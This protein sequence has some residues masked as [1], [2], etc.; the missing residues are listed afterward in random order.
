MASKLRTLRLS[1]GK[2][3][4]FRFPDEE[5]KAIE[6]AA[7]S[8][9]YTWTD[10]ARMLIDANPDAPNRAALLRRA[11]LE[12]AFGHA[13]LAER[14]EL[15]QQGR[16]LDHPMLARRF[17]PMSDGALEAELELMG[18]PSYRADCQSFELIAGFHKEWIDGKEKQIPVVIIRN[19]LEGGLH[20][21]LS[22]DDVDPH[23]APDLGLDDLAFDEHDIFDDLGKAT[24]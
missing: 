17:W 7:E 16:E 9:G 14:A 15:M 22:R 4:S 24:P 18:K 1:D 5:W 11:A 12:E 3:T 23:P 2:T 6:R 8:R 20:I 19:K 13:M 21:L 10:W